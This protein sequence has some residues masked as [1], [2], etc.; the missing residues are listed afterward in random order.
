[1]GKLVRYEE[2]QLSGVLVI[3]YFIGDLLSNLKENIQYVS[4][5]LTS[6]AAEM[7]FSPELARRCRASLQSVFLAKTLCV[8]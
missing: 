5:I 4:L 3:E 8:L 6:P 7:S 2:L 1:M